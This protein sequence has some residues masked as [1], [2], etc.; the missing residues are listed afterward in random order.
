ML[1]TT[2]QTVIP[3]ETQA[4]WEQL[5]CDLSVIDQNY[6]GAVFANSLAAEDMVIQHAI[7]TK[8]LGITSFC[9]DTGRLHNETLSLLEL[10][11]QHYGIEITRLT[12]NAIDIKK[13]VTQYGTHAFYESV[14]LRK[15]CCTL[16]KVEPLKAYLQTKSAWI[17][18][19]RR[20]QS[21]TR[22]ALE[23]SEFDQSF[24]L[25]KFNPL[26]DWTH[27]QVWSVIRHHNIP[28]NPLHDQGYPSI[29]CEPC[30]RAIRPDED[31]RAGRW[32]WEQR[33][34]LECGLH[35]NPTTTTVN[36]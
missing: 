1:T 15:A 27:E 18:G 14:S 7:H 20:T 11:N 2:A 34:S 10:V 36:T 22:Q 13:H 25:Q 21:Q 26:C 19:Q 9:L 17:T 30:T 4:L 24:N 32:W 16:R 28:Y 23:K 8:M 35:S 6:T 33:D 3:P 29:G 12:P 31:I 5:L